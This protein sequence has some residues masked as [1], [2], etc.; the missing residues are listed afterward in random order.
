MAE[1]DMVS[2]NEQ[3]GEGNNRNRG[4]HVRS[5]GT[6]ETSSGFSDCV[7][8]G[9]ECLRVIV[10]E[11]ALELRLFQ[12][13]VTLPFLLFAL[14][15]SRVL[16]HCVLTHSGVQCEILRGVRE[17]EVRGAHHTVDARKGE[18]QIGRAHV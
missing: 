15:F 9:L 4:A 16:D 14:G 11:I 6:L 12:I 5:I 1:S 17:K 2:E 8:F 3:Q 10:E 18:E 13:N 7:R